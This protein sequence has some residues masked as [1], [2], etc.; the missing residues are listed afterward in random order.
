MPN[1]PTPHIEAKEGEIAKTVLLAGD[2]KRVT[3]MAKKMLKRERCVSSIRGNV[4]YTGLYDGKEVSIMSCGMGSGSMGIYSY[5]LYNFYGV[6]NIIRVGTA[7]S[8]D[9]K[10]HIGDIVVAKSVVTDTNLYKL[11]DEN[12]GE[13]TFHSSSE[14]LKLLSSQIEENS[15]PKPK[16][17]RKLP[18]EDG[19]PFPIV[20]KLIIRASMRI[21]DLAERIKERQEIKIDKDRIFFGKVYSSETFYSN[22]DDALKAK[23]LCVEMEAGALYAT[24]KKL[25]KNAIA[26]L[27]ISDEILTGQKLSSKDRETKVEAMFKLALDL[28]TNG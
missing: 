3:Y 19:N 8:I 7:G 5:E 27:T 16:Q 20:T 6:E 14:Q 21:S 13:T 18:F 15:K 24:A 26:L 1:T 28:A 2:P 10:I 9:K 12:A 25:K 17:E 11:A 4:C 23:A 22:S